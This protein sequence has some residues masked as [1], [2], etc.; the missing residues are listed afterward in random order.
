MLLT[1]NLRSDVVACFSTARVSFGITFPKA[2]RFGKV[3][4]ILAFLEQFEYLGEH[5]I[6]GHRC[7]FHCLGFYSLLAPKMTQN[8]YEGKRDAGRWHNRSGSG[9]GAHAIIDTAGTY[10]YAGL[11]LKYTLE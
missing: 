5:V 11:R 7:P 1:S 10:T 4:L 9:G 8:G 6:E 2:G 3:P